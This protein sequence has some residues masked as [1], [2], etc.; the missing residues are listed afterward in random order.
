[1][2]FRILG[3]LEVVADGRPVPIDR[4]LSRALLAYL[5]LHANEPVSSDRLVDQLWGEDA[6]RTAVASLRNYVS[7][8]RRSIGSERLRL[9]SA[10]YVLHI[11]PERFDLAQFNR[12][13]AEAQGASAKK[14]AESLRAALALRR[15]A[16]LEDLAFEEFAQA[17]IAQLEERLLSALEDRIDADLE[18]GCG[19]ELV[20]ELEELVAAHPLRERLRAQQ[21][22]ALYRAGRQADA[23]AAFRAARQMLRD[24]LGLEPGERLR[25]LER[26]ILEQDPALD[27]EAPLATTTESRR[28]V[29]FLFCEIVGSSLLASELDPEVHRRLL[30]S[31]HDTARRS[32]ETHGGLIERV[33][34]NVVVGLFGAPDLHEDDALRAVRAAVDLRGAV[35]ALQAAHDLRARIAL[36]TGEVVTSIVGS[37]VDVAG[38]AVDVAAELARRG[39]ESEILLAD[40]TRLL[41]RD[42]VHAERTDLGERVVA[43][44]FEELIAV[45]TSAPPR[46]VGRGR[47]LHR[48][49]AVFNRARTESSCL[50]MTIVG[51]PGIGKTR[52]AREFLESLRADA[53]VLVGHCASY[54]AGATYLPIAEMLRSIAPE[55][56]ARGITALLRGEEQGE[57]VAQLVA[58]AVGFAEGPPVQ[59][60]TFWAIR[61]LLEAI[62]RN[63]PLVM[64]LDDLHWAEPTLLDLVEYIGNW[65]NGPIFLVCLARTELL[66]RRPGWASVSSS[67]LLIELGP[68]GS[69]QMGM[70]LD[71]FAG[72]SIAVETRERIAEQAGGNP[73]FAEQLLALTADVPNAD[74][75]RAPPTLEA[76]IAARLDHLDPSELQLLQRAAVIGRVFEHDTLADLAPLVEA[77]VASLR[78]KALIHT[79][80]LEPGYRFH[81]ALVRDVAYRSIPKALR[82]E[83]HEQLANNLHRRDRPDELVGYHFEQAYRFRLELEG[84]DE[85]SKALAEEASER[86]VSAGRRAFGRNDLN[87]AVS[88]LTRASELLPALDRRKPSLLIEIAE[89]QT[90]FGRFTEADEYLREAASSTSEERDQT[91]AGIAS[92]LWRLEVDPHCDLQQAQTDAERAAQLFESLGD[93]RAAAS[94]CELLSGLAVYRCQFADAQQAA[95]R[96]VA[97]AERCRDPRVAR[98]ERFVLTAATYGPIPTS[99]ALT[100]AETML[101]RFPGESFHAA[102]MRIDVSRLRAMRGEFDTARQLL[103]EASAYDQ[104]G[105]GMTGTH[106]EQGWWVER[107]SGD[108]QA[109]EQELRCE[110]EICASHGSTSV[111]STV[112]AQLAYCYCSLNQLEDADEFT[113]VCLNY[114]ADAD[115]AS[116]VLSRQARARVIAHHGRLAEA[117]TL[118]RE[119]CALAHKTDAPELQA[120]ALMDL[121][122]VLRLSARTSEARSAAMQALHLYVGKEHIVGADRARRLLR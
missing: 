82:A 20:A 116:H 46:L 114:A 104:D 30:S 49:S 39:D 74:L 6:P 100:L 63:L 98:Y 66:E 97:H 10:G 101:A 56:S 106:G 115:V 45:H 3:P 102:A 36:N 93:G 121:A 111:L 26:R 27:R 72:E 33:S 122:N 17:E 8:L 65:A 54:G 75:D 59:G 90:A 9:E 76:L 73:L 19:A 103:R 29:T 117:E 21:M 99:Q 41:V 64:A 68:L 77:D 85:H 120:D 2:E 88:L 40:T 43:W 105:W 94:A 61:R 62:A 23:L 31:Y 18:L 48:L 1:M 70:L 86:L 96:A 109:A 5:L 28:T 4:R 16:P 118:A 57:H 67:D 37:D 22:L 53:H 14:R 51:E 81:H 78:R 11:D 110:Y 107:L 52:L 60:E 80:K 112:A 108:W 113:R 13:V 38:L 12:L 50:T 92:W 42:H 32:I 15:G 89:A 79:L 95:E 58:E 55:A 25:L 119:A 71:E 47:E 24:E 7:R 34:G 87:A 35:E 44:R 69:A 91:L 83:L 84:F